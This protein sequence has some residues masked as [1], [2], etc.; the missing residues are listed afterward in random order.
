[1]FAG[2]NRSNSP[3]SGSLISVP[4]PGVA[5]VSRVRATG[6]QTVSD[7]PRQT[8]ATGDVVVKVDRH[9]I[10]GRG[11]V[12]EGLVEVDVG[13]RLRQRG[14]LVQPVVEPVTRAQ[15]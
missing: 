12:P 13:G 1:M 4:M 10:A 7:D 5:S 2:L 8:R 9:R 14:L 11:R 3:S 15:F 6:A